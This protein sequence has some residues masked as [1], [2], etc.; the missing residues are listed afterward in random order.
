MANAAKSAAATTSDA[1]AELML[2][3]ATPVNL[4][5]WPLAR[6]P[7]AAGVS[8]GVS[9][10]DILDTV[11]VKVH[12]FL[13]NALDASVSAPVPE[14][15]G[16]T[17]TDSRGRALRMLSRV[18]VNGRTGVKEL[19]VAPG[20][21]VPLMLLYAAAE[22]GEVR[23]TL[24]VGSRAV[25]GEIPVR[26][27]GVAGGTSGTGKS[28]NSASGAAGATQQG[29]GTRVTL[30][31]VALTPPRGWG[32][33]DQKGIPIF[34]EPSSSGKDVSF[35]A[36][37][38]ASRVRGPLRDWVRSQW[39]GKSESA[40]GEWNEIGN[41]G[42]IE[43]SIWTSEKRADGVEVFRRYRAVQVNDRAMLLVGTSTSLARDRQM[44]DRMYDVSSSVTIGG[45]GPGGEEPELPPA[46]QPAPVPAP[47]P[48]PKPEAAPKPAPP[49]S[50]P[51]PAPAAGKP[52]FVGTYFS[53]GTI[54]TKLLILPN[55]TW[56]TA[57]SKGRWTSKDRMIVLDGNAQ[58]WCGGRGILNAEE[59]QLSF[60]CVSKDGFAM[61]I[62]FAKYS[63][64]IQR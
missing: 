13:E 60:D 27:A 25:V 39:Q 34:L 46:P 54:N 41:G 33:A 26:M 58:G 36:V 48:A 32:R 24:R 57:Q 44:I 20:K 14:D 7:L 35:I 64:E 8:L 62:S 21:R 40:M 12:A 5:A 53:W 38:P 29:A 16:F 61:N 42:S 49:R 23:A 2:S 55:G 45:K 17:L 63:K 4:S 37:S 6:I 56:E 43:G 59:T 22:P 3:K 50:E 18:R 10:V 15:A 11:G 9:Q 52:N 30:G 51:A 1:G 28:A 19:V 47:R 31:D